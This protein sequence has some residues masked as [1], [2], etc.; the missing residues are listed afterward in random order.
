MIHFEAEDLPELMD[1]FTALP[2]TVVVDH[3]GRPDV[4]KPVDG[5]EFA[6]L[7]DLMRRHGNVWSK[8]SCPDRVLWGTECPVP[9]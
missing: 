9:S 8:V 7:V 3:M 6:L 1:F 5:E 4:A 2:T